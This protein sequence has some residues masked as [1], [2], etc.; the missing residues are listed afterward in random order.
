MSRKFKNWIGGISIGMGVLLGI[1]I[2][3]QFQLMPLLLPTVLIL[4]GIAAL[5]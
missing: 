2:L 5:K 3:Y 1:A 4:A